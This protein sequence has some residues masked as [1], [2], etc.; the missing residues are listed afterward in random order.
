M[1]SPGFMANQA[2]QQAA[3][4]ASRA[5]QQAAQ[6]ASAQASRAAQ[7]AADQ[8]RSAAHR[9][10]EQ[11]RQASAAHHAAMLTRTGGYPSAGG[12]FGRVV[13][14][15]LGLVVLVVIVVVGLIVLGV[16]PAAF[17]PISGWLSRLF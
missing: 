7:Q 11:A 5:A 2:A 6:Q 1:S 17:G 13:R 10:S 16:D 14:F 8:A 3:A 12:A 15:F 9:S 4:Q